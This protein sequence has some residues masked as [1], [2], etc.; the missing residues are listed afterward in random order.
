MMRVISISRDGLPPFF[1]VVQLVQRTPRGGWRYMVAGADSGAHVVVTVV[2][3]R[4]VC[5]QG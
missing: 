3:L 4:S 2:E 1:V 5:Q